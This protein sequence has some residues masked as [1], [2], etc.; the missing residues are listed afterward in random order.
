MREALLKSI[1]EYDMSEMTICTL[2]ITRS[3]SGYDQG[4]LKA[5]PFLIPNFNC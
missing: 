3:S 4:G 5:R 2:I 1:G